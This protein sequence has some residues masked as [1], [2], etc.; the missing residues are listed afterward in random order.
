MSRAQL[1]TAFK[2]GAWSEWAAERLYN[3]YKNRIHMPSFRVKPMLKYWYGGRRRRLTAYKRKSYYRR[4]RY[5]RM[6]S[7]RARHKKDMFGAHNF[8][9]PVN[10]SNCKTFLFDSASQATQ[11]W[12]TRTLYNF[13][14]VGIGQGFG[15]SERLRNIVNLRGVKASATYLNFAPQPIVLHFALIKPKSQFTVSTTDFFRAENNNNTRQESFTNSRSGNELANLH[16]NAD[17]YVVLYHVRIPINTN[18]N[19]GTGGNTWGKFE[20]YKPIKRQLAFDDTTANPT[21]AVNRLYWCFWYD[22]ITEPPG[23]VPVQNELN[24]Q[25]RIVTY[26]REPKN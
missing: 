4:P 21:N 18:S 17:Q 13:E 3:R 16:I 5:H 14:I 11:T 12:D 10:S 15:S 2:V 25:F 9:K 22:R 24:M 1:A 8:G 7:K 6:R 19:Q 20:H 26:W 23:A